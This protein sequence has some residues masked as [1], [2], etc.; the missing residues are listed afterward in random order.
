VNGC[1]TDLCALSG[2]RKVQREK[3]SSGP[4]GEKKE[5]TQGLHMRGG[6]TGEDRFEGTHLCGAESRG[7]V[8]RADGA[9]DSRAGSQLIEFKLRQLLKTRVQEARIAA[10]RHTLRRSRKNMPSRKIIL[11]SRRKKRKS[12]SCNP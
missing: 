3:V 9:W 12:L 8:Y 2:G 5:R 10:A 7:P 1:G 6:G 11:C 4:L